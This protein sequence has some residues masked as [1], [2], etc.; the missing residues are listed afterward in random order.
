MQW[1]RQD[2]AGRRQ[3]AVSVICCSAATRSPRIVM[4]WANAASTEEDPSRAALCGELR[5]RTEAR[6]VAGARFTV[7]WC[8]EH[9]RDAQVLLVGADALGLAQWPQELVVRRRRLHRKLRRTLS[10]LQADP[11][12]VNAAL[13]DIPYAVV[14][15]HLLSGASIPAST[16]AIVEDCARALIPHS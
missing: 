15:R 7:Q 1:A 11:D 13:I 2:A 16:D 8:H 9:P 10:G 3:R 4:M 14:R 5:I 6:C 12:R